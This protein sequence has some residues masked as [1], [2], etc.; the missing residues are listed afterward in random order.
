MRAI[1]LGTGAGRADPDRFSPS[2]VVWVGESPVL[3]DCGSGAL[4]RL[5]QAGLYPAEIRHVFFTHM[6]FDHYADYGYLMIE[7][8]IG[9][10]A[11]SRGNLNVFGPPGTARF[12]R[13]VELTYDAE[14][15]GYA[16]LEGYERARDLCRANVQE[17][18]HGW[19]LEMNGWRITTAQ[20]DHGLVKLPSFAYRF[21]SPEGR[22]LVFSGDTMPCDGIVSLARN[23]D[24]LVHESTLPEAE[25]EL[26]RA[27]G[28]AVQIHSTPRQAGWVA[29]EA[30]VRKL[31]LNHFAAWNSFAPDRPAYDWDALAPREAAREFA[32]EIVVGHDLMEIEIA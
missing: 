13:N 28:F 31:V 17:T 20:V 26:R 4:Y 5:R 15:D 10:A 11:F 29:Q 21:D 6:H 18:Y 32:G 3:V 22:S 9:E 7:P 24:V 12:V 25:L 14:L 16:A 19:S 1:L 27:S 2:N 30:N 23:A 8:L